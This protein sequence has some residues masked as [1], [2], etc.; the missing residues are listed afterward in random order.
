MG[1][2]KPRAEKHRITGEYEISTGTARVRTDPD[3]DGAY[4]LEINNV[5]SSPIVLGSPR[6]LLFDYM[7]WAAAA[8]EEFFAA[9]RDP[10]QLHLT[11]LGGAACTLPRYFADLW[12]DSRNLVVEID[13]ALATYVRE[14]FDFPDP[15][16]V[17]IVVGEAR[18]ETHRLPPASTDLIIRDV[19][20]G[21]SIPE[22]LCTLEF[23][24]AA[25]CA[26]TPGG[27]YLANHAAFPGLQTTRKELAG[28]REVFPHVAAIADPGILAGRAYGNMA[29]LGSD[30]PIDAEGLRR[31]L[32]EDR[33]RAT[34]RGGDWVAEV[35]GA[36]RPR[37]DRT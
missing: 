30:L 22:H 33:T 27:L 7:V 2:G 9:R 36:I 20:A 24:A 13:A 16:A 19:F 21:G 3:R 28:M 5:P 18:T 26:L 32:R 15:P 12:P 31:R 1:K 6:V 14:W 23:F 35:V 10:A 4:L 37:H 11:H 29:L 25:R 34:V 8:V 17:S